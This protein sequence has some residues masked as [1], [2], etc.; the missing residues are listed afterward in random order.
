MTTFEFVEFR[1]GAADGRWWTPPFD[2]AVEYEHPHWWNRQLGDAPWLVQVIEDG[3][4]VG[5][6]SSTTP[7]ASTR[8][9]RTYRRSGTSGWRSSSSR[10]PPRLVDAVSAVE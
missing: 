5:G 1:R 7:A 2:E 6:S 3:T 10:W 4:E 9:T 8:S